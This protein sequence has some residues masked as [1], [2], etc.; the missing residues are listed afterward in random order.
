MMSDL[1]FQV[2]LYPSSVTF[3]PVAPE[4]KMGDS[5]PV[6]TVTDVEEPD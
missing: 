3:S 2:Q 1:E 6:A 5:N 4:S